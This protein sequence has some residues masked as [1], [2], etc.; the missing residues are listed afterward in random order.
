[1]RDALEA[2]CRALHLP[3]DKRID[4]AIGIVFRPK[5]PVTS[6]EFR[7]TRN[8]PPFGREEAIEILRNLKAYPTPIRS[9]PEVGTLI[10]HAAKRSTDPIDIDCPRCGPSQGRR[11]WVVASWVLCFT[12]RQW[13]MPP[14][15]PLRLTR[16]PKATTSAERA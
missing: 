7:Q 6:V 8:S 12:C 5:P 4:R 2:R 10:A 15:R 3:L 16:E 1:M 13:D 11:S 14:S 9:M